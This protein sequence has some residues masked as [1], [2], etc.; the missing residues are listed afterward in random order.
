MD[1]VTHMAISPELTTGLI[2]IGATLAGALPGLITGFL[3]R[4][5]DDKKQLRELVLKTSAEHW[6][7]IVE[8]TQPKAMLPLELYMIHTALMCDLAF[9][10]KKLT[11]ESVK[12]H[13]EETSKIME[14]MTEHALSVST[15]KKAL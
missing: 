9:G 8:K 4:K 2:A 11:P 5:S 12:K 14:V 3:S 15:K 13:L 1:S 10:D 7:F 6:Q